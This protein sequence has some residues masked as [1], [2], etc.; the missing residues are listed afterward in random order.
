MIANPHATTPAAVCT[1]DGRPL[2]MNALSSGVPRQSRAR[3]A[4]AR[5]SRHRREGGAR[6]GDPVGAGARAAATMTCMAAIV[7]PIA[8]PRDVADWAYVG[9]CDGPPVHT[10]PH[11]SDR[12]SRCKPRTA[13]GPRA[14][15][16]RRTVRRLAVPRRTRTPVPLRAASR[17]TMLRSGSRT[18]SIGAWRRRQ[19]TWSSVRRPVVATLAGVFGGRSVRALLAAVLLVAMTVLPAAR[20]QR[21]HA[22]AQPHRVAHLRHDRPRPSSSRSPIRTPRARRPTTSA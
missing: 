19:S 2:G 10:G 22:P 8:R 1:A 7:R 16:V 17:L 18:R 11:R 5:T 12:A 14:P 9:G 15:P 3:A 6:H 4:P 20:R 21:T 13:R